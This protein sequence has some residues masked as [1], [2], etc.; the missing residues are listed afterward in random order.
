MGNCPTCPECPGKNEPCFV[1]GHILLWGGVASIV[2]LAII[3][4]VGYICHWLGYRKGMRKGFD[5]GEYIEKKRQQK[6]KENVRLEND[7]VYKRMMLEVLDRSRSFRK[8]QQNDCDGNLNGAQQKPSVAHVISPMILDSPQNNLQ[9]NVNQNSVTQ[10]PHFHSN[11]FYREATP[12][13]RWKESSLP[14]NATQSPTIHLRDRSG[15][16][17]RYGLSGETSLC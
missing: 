7:E 2:A 17:H 6:M 15:H 4:L 8:N 9:Q 12:V 3:I 11:Q 13:S 10:F 5:K 14:A 16:N 1:R